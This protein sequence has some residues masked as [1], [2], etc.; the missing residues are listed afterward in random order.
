MRNIL[1]FSLLTLLT[2]QQSHTASLEERINHGE[3]LLTTIREHTATSSSTSNSLEAK[4]LTNKQ[5]LKA[6]PEEDLEVEITSLNVNLAASSSGCGVTG[7]QKMVYTFMNGDFTSLRTI[8][9]DDTIG[10]DFYTKEITKF[11]STEHQSCADSADIEKNISALT[12]LQMRRR[13]TTKCKS[14]LEW[15]FPKLV[16]T[17]RKPVTQHYDIGFGMEMGVIQNSTHQYNE[18]V[19]S[20]GYLHRLAMKTIEVK[21][22]LPSNF[23]RSDIVL[24]GNSR[25]S[26]YGGE[27]DEKTGIVTFIKKTYLA[28]MNRYTVRV[29]FPTSNNTLQ[30]SPCARVDDWLMAALLV[31]FFLCFIIPCCLHLYGKDSVKRRGVRS[32]DDDP[33]EPRFDGE[34]RILSNGSRV[35][36]DAGEEENVLCGC[37]CTRPDEGRPVTMESGALLGGSGGSGDSL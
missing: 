28:P 2:L 22:Q 13:A 32:R 33:N 19:Y 17:D 24:M 30:C 21:F 37:C 11:N 26:A 35:N 8:I 1:F 25:D 4:L 10:I 36:Y 34:G 3:S 14:E 6:S 29:W 7:R 23:K 12:C 9:G 20:T 31:P 27:Y 16:A 18:M 15:E 5:S